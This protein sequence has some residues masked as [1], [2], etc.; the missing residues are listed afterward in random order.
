MNDYRTSKKSK[1]FLAGGLIC[2]LWVALMVGAVEAGSD[3]QVLAQTT[4]T[5]QAES[6]QTPTEPVVTK[7]CFECHPDKMDAWVDSPHAHSADTPVFLEGWENLERSPECLLCHKATYQQDTGEYLAE[8][9]SCET[10]HGVVG[11]DH[12]PAQAPAR[13]DEEYCGTCHPTTLGEARISGHSTENEVRCV[14]CH[15]PH[16]Q[17]VLFKNPDDMCKDCH[18]EDLKKM[19][20][21]LS[22]VHLQEDISCADCHMLDVPHT[23]V[24]NFQHEDTT[25]FFKGF[26]C[27]SEISVSVAQ[28]TGTDHEILGS[29]VEEQMNW[30]VVHRVSRLESAPQCADCHIMDEKLRADFTAL[31]YSSEELDD[32]SWDS[33][34]FPV[35]AESELN[36]LVARPK[37]NWNW[38]Y[39][40]AGIA[41]VFGI[42]E[43]TVIYKLEGSSRVGLMAGLASFFRKRIARKKDS[44]KDDQEGEE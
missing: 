6:T 29:Y 33:Q 36:K 9:V 41:I 43:F 27:T 7:D 26:D 24:F 19:D 15:D 28:R 23:F 5:P 13:S 22:K 44:V 10:C 8:G 16:S 17:K 20:E 38:I 11:P 12:P 18:D 2:L 3:P 37:K 34:E 21:T 32:M 30:P 1:I 14:D 39:G 4:A 31:G 42:F 40:L 35:L 25:S